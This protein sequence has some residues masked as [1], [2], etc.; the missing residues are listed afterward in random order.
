MVLLSDLGLGKLAEL[1]S[2]FFLSSFVIGNARD[3]IYICVRMKK[4]GFWITR[5]LF[6]L[7]RFCPVSV[8]LLLSCS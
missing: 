1:V 8:L 5:L 3:H 4:G 2:C 7:R 6:V